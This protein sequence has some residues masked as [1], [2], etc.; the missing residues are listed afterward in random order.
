MWDTHVRVGGAQGSDLDLATCPK[1]SGLNDRCICAS[2]LFHV[3]K[4][5]SGYFENVWVWLAD[6]YV[7]MSVFSLLKHLWIKKV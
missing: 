3:T 4:Q 2:L 6:Q 1:L 5:A 7:L